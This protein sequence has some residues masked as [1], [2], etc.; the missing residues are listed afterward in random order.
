ML[1]NVFDY[2]ALAQ[3]HLDGG[4][5][6]YF[7]GGAGDEITLHANRTAFER[8][9]SRPRLLVNVSAIEMNT[10]VLGTDLVLVKTGCNSILFEG[11]IAASILFY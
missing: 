3:K 1:V 8:I 7:S 11:I 10:S 9:R 5:W 6:A 2:E 4:T